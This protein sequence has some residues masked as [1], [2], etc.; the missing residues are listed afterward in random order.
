[1]GQCASSTSEQVVVVPSS[2]EIALHQKANERTM[3]K[4]DSLGPTV[5][6]ESIT[7]STD[8]ADSSEDTQTAPDDPKLDLIQDEED[9]F[10]DD[11]S[12]SKPQPFTQRRFRRYTSKTHEDSF[13][14]SFFVDNIDSSWCYMG[15][16][17]AS[18]SGHNSSSSG[19]VNHCR[20]RPS[21]DEAMASWGQMNTSVLLSNNNNNNKAAGMDASMTCMIPTILDDSS[22]SGRLLSGSSSSSNH[23]HQNDMSMSSWSEMNTSLDS[24]NSGPC[25]MRLRYSGPCSHNS[26]SAVLDPYASMNG[27]FTIQELEECSTFMAG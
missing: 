14:D 7:A 27:S 18:S 4:K 21:V 12:L 5:L 23:Q 20:R 11:A 16:S 17:G 9:Q 3:Q 2:I 24:A 15:M 19:C 10:N 13:E 25:H 22:K 8:I 26:K 1:M 6:K